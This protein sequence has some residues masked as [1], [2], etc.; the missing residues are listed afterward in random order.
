[1]PTRARRKNSTLLV[2]LLV[3][4]GSAAADSPTDVSTANVPAY[5]S[6][7]TFDAKVEEYRREYGEFLARRRALWDGY[8][9]SVV[10]PVFKSQSDADKKRMEDT[11]AALDDCG[12]DPEGYGPATDEYHDCRGGLFEKLMA[13]MGYETYAEYAERNGGDPEPP[14]YPVYHLEPAPP[15]AHE[16]AYEEAKK[17]CADK[18]G[19]W[20]MQSHGDGPDAYFNWLRCWKHNPGEPTPPPG[21]PFWQQ[22]PLLPYDAV[23]THDR[24]S[25]KV[26]KFS[27]ESQDQTTRE[28]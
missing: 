21:D 4:A 13:A 9:D 10:T 18:G 7:D 17:E 3:L 28:H 25:H 6:H 5:D 20:V 27:R 23:V 1:M 8:M 11:S 26:L 15:T 16:I 14:T 2:G 22:E 19:S 12:D 24:R